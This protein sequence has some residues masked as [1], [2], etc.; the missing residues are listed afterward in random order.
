MF[1]TA[2]FFFII[3]FILLPH[4]H[5]TNLKV[6]FFSDLDFKSSHLEA[7]MACKRD[8]FITP[9]LRAFGFIYVMTLIWKSSLTFSDLDLILRSPAHGNQ[10][11]L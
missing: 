4:V 9:Q 3:A 8:N 2:G 5:D 6:G 10:N 1:R 11:G 7:K